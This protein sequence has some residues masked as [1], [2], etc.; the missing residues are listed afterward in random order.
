M[1]WFSHRWREIA[2]TYAPPVASSIQGALD[3]ATAKSV[4]F[5]VTTLVWE[6]QDCGKLRRLECLGPIKSR[7]A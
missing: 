1:C 2:T 7:P 4:M 3:M 5:G 6:C